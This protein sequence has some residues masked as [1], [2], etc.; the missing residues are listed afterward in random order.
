MSR[1]IPVVVAVVAA[2]L[3]GC[4]P[5][6]VELRYRPVAGSRYIYRIVVHSRTVTT[7]DSQAPKEEVDEATLRAEHLV[8]RSDADGTDVEVRLT[9]VATDAGLLGVI[10]GTGGGPVDG[11]VGSPSTFLV[12]LDRAAQLTEVQRVEGVD[13]Q[14]LGD[15][16]LSEIFPAAAG[17]P[18]DRPLHPGDSWE[19]DEPLRLAGLA[20]GHLRGRGRLVSLGVQDGRKIATVDTDADLAIR[21]DEVTLGKAGGVALTGTQTTRARVTR[22]VVDGA[23]Q[24]VDA[25]TTA[26]FRIILLPPPGALGPPVTGTLRVELHSL[27]T[28]EI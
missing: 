27:T 20:P 5:D 28:R 10:G 16:G 25:T 21:P 11:P 12:R 4:Q 23:V 14:L 18:P 9:S 13:A 8:Q 15:L 1:R 6:T 17:A 7:L 2:L 3:T 24:T 19:I 26:V 22:D